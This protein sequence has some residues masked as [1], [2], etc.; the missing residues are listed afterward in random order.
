MTSSTPASS[1]IDLFADE[2]LTDPYPRYAQLRDLGAVVHLPA[3][4][5]YA[6]TRYDVI[7]DALGDP[8]TFSSPDDR[9]QPDGQRGAPGHVAGLR[10]ADP[11]RTARDAFREP[12]PAGAART[13]G[14]DPDQGR[15]AGRRTGRQ[16]IV[17]GHRRAGPR[18]PA[19]GRRGP[20]RLHRPRARQHAALGTGRHGGHRP[21]EPADRREL[22]DRRRALRLVLRGHRRGP[23]A[24]LGG[25]RHLR[26]RGPG[27]HSRRTPPATSS[28]STSAPAST[29]R[30]PRSATSS[31]S[32]AAHPDQFDLVRENP[33]LVPAAFNEV[34]R[35]WAPVHAWGRLVTKD[36]E[37]DGTIV[38]AGAQVAILLR[39]R[40]P[41]PPALREP[42]RLPGRAQPGRP[43]LL[44]LRP[45]R[46]RRPGP[47]PAE[48]HAVIEALAS[49]VQRLVAGEPVRV[50]SNIT[51]SIEEL[52]VLEVVPA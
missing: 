4:D 32:S 41:R 38:P 36:V 12:L 1:D 21:D 47:R 9:L 52:H 15:C 29:P 3:N 20:D 18:L 39:C 49:R 27:R 7:R 2:V 37:I 48:A 45:A 35:F 14:S 24:R 16:G 25:P 23:G 10:P 17:R 8:G 26:R 19:R 31:R 11:H 22:P 50:P 43:P 44:R 40:Q 33:S 34:L 13:E 28:T 46:L 5:V 42:G 51:R 6:L 30:S